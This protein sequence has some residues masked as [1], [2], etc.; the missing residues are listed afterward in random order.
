MGRVF[1]WAGVARMSGWD[2]C[3][4]FPSLSMLTQCVWGAI[5]RPLQKTGLLC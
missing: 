4:R 5:N 3:G 1:V 2:P